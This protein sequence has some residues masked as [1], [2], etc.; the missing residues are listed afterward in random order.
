M[1]GDHIYMFL[2]WLLAILGTIK[3][4][5]F[6]PKLIKYSSGNCY[7]VLI[8]TPLLSSPNQILNGPFMPVD[9]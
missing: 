8:L 9:K 5:G 1:K 2:L 6:N 4:V 3:Y 7:T